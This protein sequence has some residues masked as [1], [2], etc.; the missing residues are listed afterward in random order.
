[1]SLK[2]PRNLTFTHN[3]MSRLVWCA[4][5]DSERKARADAER[6]AK[7]GKTEDAANLTEWADDCARLAS[8]LNSI[9]VAMNKLLATSFAF[10]RVNDLRQS[11]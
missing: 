7:K 2:F 10:R 6:A 3:E 9:S 5:I 1:M 4:L 8:R 11:A